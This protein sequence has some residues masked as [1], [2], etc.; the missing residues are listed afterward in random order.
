M[1]RLSGGGV[2][3]YA[4]LPTYAQSGAPTVR[5]TWALAASSL[6]AASLV[7]TTGVS[8]AAEPKVKRAVLGTILSAGTLEIAKKP[9]AW[10]PAERGAPVLEDSEL[11]TGPGKPAMI[12][13]GKHGIVA[14][15]ESSRLRVGPATVEGLPVYLGP[16]SELSLR[17]PVASGIYV[18]TDSAVIRGPAS[19]PTS[20]AEGEFV[21]G[22]VARRGDETVVSVLSGDLRVRNRDGTDYV[23][24][25]TGQNV[26]IADPSAEP[27]PVEMAEADEK[28]ARRRMAGLGWLGTRNGMIIAGATLGLAGAGIGIGLGVSGGGDGGGGGGGGGGGPSSPF[29][30]P[31]TSSSSGP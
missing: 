17:L 7:L 24:V 18:L 12:G 9:N 5:G 14:L 22:T 16:E 25:A 13:L 30:P 27:K 19:G 26:A 15:S 3:K 31:S 28:K 29:R 6:I 10:E 8:L 4:K 2:A 23:N 20:P 11:R 21:Q 1:G